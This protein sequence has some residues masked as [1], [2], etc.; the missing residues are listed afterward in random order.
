[1]Q[2]VSHTSNKTI[3]R[4]VAQYKPVTNATGEQQRSGIEE[5]WPKHHVSGLVRRCVAISG[6]LPVKHLDSKSDSD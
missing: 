3:A 5:G 1:M 4:Q 2:R 6:S